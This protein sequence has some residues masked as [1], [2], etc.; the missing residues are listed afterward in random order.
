[1]LN[2]KQRKSGTKEILTCLKRSHEV[3]EDDIYR[4]YLKIYA[5]NKIK[6]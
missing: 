2:Y 4:K 1:M 3:N 5:L 6:K